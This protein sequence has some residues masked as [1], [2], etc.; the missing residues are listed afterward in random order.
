MSQRIYKLAIAFSLLFLFAACSS[1]T[2]RIKTEP[3]GAKV[4]I[5]GELVGKSPTVYFS[6]GSSGRRYHIQLEKEGY[7]EVDLYLDNRLNWWAPSSLIF[8]GFGGLYMGLAG[9]SLAGE[10]QFNLRAL[11]SVEPAATTDAKESLEVEEITEEDVAKKI[12][13]AAPKTAMDELDESTKDAAAQE[14]SVDKDAATQEPAVESAE[15]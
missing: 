11:S 3:S 14:P 6:K 12:E 7:E 1:V 10:Y 8:Y 9:W 4:Y 2:T 13:E 5:D 15:P